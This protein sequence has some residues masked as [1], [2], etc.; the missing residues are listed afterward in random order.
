MNE[1]IQNIPQEDNNNPIESPQ[2][3]KELEIVQRLVEQSK[4]EQPLK[5]EEPVVDDFVP[6]NDDDDNSEDDKLEGFKSAFKP[7]DSVDDDDEEEEQKPQVKKSAFDQPVSEILAG[8][9]PA[10]PSCC[11]TSSV[12]GGKLHVYDWLEDL[13][14]PPGASDLVEVQFKNT[15]KSYYRNQSGVQLHKGDIV[16]VESS[17]GHD[18]GVVTL[19]GRLVYLQMHKYHINPATYEFKKVYRI[20]RPTDIEKWEEAKSLEQATMLESRQIAER[21][22]LNMKIGDVEYQGDR[23]KAIFYYIADERVDFRELIKVLADRF[24]VRIEMKQ[25]GARQEAGRIGG[26]GPCGRELCCAS[27]M[28][29]FVSVT[30]HSARVQDLSLNPLKLAG[31]CGKLKCCLNYELDVYLDAIQSFPP[32]DKPLET[33]DG[34]YYFFK[35]DIFKHLMWYSP[36]KDTPMNIV[37]V[38]ADHVREIQAMN[39]NGQKPKELGSSEQVAVSEEMGYNNVVELDDLTRFDNKNRRGGN[40]NNRDNNRGGNRGG[41]RDNNHNNR[42][43][44]NP[45]GQERRNNDRRNNNGG[46]NNRP[47]NRNNRPNNGGNREGGNRNNNNNGGNNAPQNNQPQQ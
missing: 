5:T 36:Q 19:S 22:N 34:T 42:R 26:I 10:T 20:A 41:N 32:T 44:D 25:I 47:N 24:H 30:T 23:T 43:N 40:R 16:A 27:W 13:P 28:T 1:D 45:Q 15:R 17:P 18:I 33:A 29:N 21:L 11:G 6:D 46:N 38:D 39:A 3:P 12:R 4:T 2:V 8:L 7:A 14:E 37:A 35:Y 31:Q 9:R